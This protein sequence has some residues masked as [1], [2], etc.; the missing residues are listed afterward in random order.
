[1]TIDSVT[2][3]RLEWGDP[4]AERRVLFIHGLSGLGHAWWRIASAVAEQGGYALAVDLRGHGYSPRT[5]EYSLSRHVADLGRVTAPEGR[6]WSLVVGH[7]LGGAASVVTAA[8]NPGWAAQLLLVDPALAIPEKDRPAV[9]ENIVRDRDVDPAEFA[10]RNPRWTSEDAL[11]K[12]TSV[13]L[14]STYMLEAI[15][16]DP[17]W[18]AEAAL[19]TLDLPV[20]ALGAD[21][22]RSPSF[23]PEQA[24]RITAANP[25]VSYREIAGEGHGMFRDAPDVVLDEILRLLPSA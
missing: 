21:R 16:A 10:A 3:A 13:R 17:G 22:D 6:P 20:H 8:T 4:A 19:T 5:R 2:L 14:V 23:P 15:L 18:D 9:L 11:L 25:R 7:S 24:E 1:M 12:A